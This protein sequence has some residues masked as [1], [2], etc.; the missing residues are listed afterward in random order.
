MANIRKPY[1]K[2][3]GTWSVRIEFYDAHKTPE[4]TSQTISHSS[5]VKVL[6]LAEQA[7][8]L[9]ENGSID[10]WSQKLKVSS[11]SAPSSQ[12]SDLLHQYIDFKT[13]FDWNENTAQ[14]ETYI[15]HKLFRPFKDLPVNKIDEQELSKQVNH[16]IAYETSKSYR[17]VVHT[18]CNWLIKHNH[19]SKPW[20]ILIKPRSNPAKIKYF[21]EQEVREL[22]RTIARYNKDLL[23]R[24][25]FRP[26][27]NTLYLIRFV[28][29]QFVTGLRLSESINLRV[30]HIRSDYFE[31]HSKGGQIERLP[32]SAVPR[33]NRLIKSQIRY[34]KSIGKHRPEQRFFLHRDPKRTSKTIKKF[35]RLAFDAHRAEELTT[36]SLRHGAAT[37]LLNSG[38]P[39][40]MVKEWLR[41][42]K[43]T[44]TERYAKVIQSEMAEAVKKAWK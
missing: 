44:T 33:L 2:K 4:R 22:Q 8:Q 12:V 7:Q 11:S 27:Q 5:K 13:T 9:Y 21:T 29:F 36:H 26:D 40:K 35:I 3:N 28:D 25:Y 37:Y 6:Q 18:F 19:L 41:H 1:K 15:L 39:L 30:K 34:L 16:G 14:S 24:G 10:P 31:I 23:K 32:Y 20:E 43:I 38:L 17:K 42:R